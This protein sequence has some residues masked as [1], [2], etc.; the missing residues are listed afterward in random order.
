MD[1]QRDDHRIA[2]MR[3]RPKDLSLPQVVY[4]PG[5][6]FIKNSGQYRIGYTMLEVDGIPDDWVQLCNALDEVWVPSTFN[7][8]TFQDQ[9]CNPPDSRDASGSQ[10]RL[11]QS[12]NPGVSHLTAL[13]IPLGV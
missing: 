4:A 3:Q 2:A 1:T 6:V 7:A 5:E 9:R 13:H 10:S 8:R 11:F 12:A